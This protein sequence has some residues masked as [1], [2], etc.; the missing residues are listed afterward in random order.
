MTSGD[1]PALGY[2]DLR[3]VSELCN[4]FGIVSNSDAPLVV[5]ADPP[6]AGVHR[7]RLRG[8]DVRWCEWPRLDQRQTHARA[9]LPQLAPLHRW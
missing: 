9:R 6:A 1:K 2:W 8:A 3:G 4:Y 5:R 7:D